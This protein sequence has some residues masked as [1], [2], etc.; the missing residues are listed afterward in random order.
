MRCAKVSLSLAIAV[1][2]AGCSQPRPAADAMSIFLNSAGC[3]PSVD[4]RP[5]EQFL[6]KGIIRGRIDMKKY[7]VF[8][9]EK[10]LSDQLRTLS[11]TGPKSSPALLESKN[12]LLAYWLNA[13]TAWTC[14]FMVIQSEARDSNRP[15]PMPGDFPL[16]GRRMTL[17]RI[18]AAILR[19]GG[20]AFLI[21]AP[22]LPPNRAPLPSGPF[23]PETLS[24]QSMENF[25]A[26]L[27]DP[28]RLVIDIDRRE[29]RF[30]P[31]IWKYRKRFAEVYSRNFGYSGTPSLLTS[32]LPITSGSA[33]RRLQDAVGY[34]CL[35]G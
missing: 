22:G 16:D 3:R 18:D 32:L 9:L 21:A 24:R 34:S 1:F 23:S 28:E 26:F 20:Y 4:Y 31:V 10:Q 29:V 17:D 11:V 27:D 19:L 15:I 2:T 33:K 8:E 13:R 5:L 35:G 7:R 25:N 12:Q 6:A 30:P 14:R